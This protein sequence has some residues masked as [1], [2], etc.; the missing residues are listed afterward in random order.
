[1]KITRIAAAVAAAA[2]APA[3]FLATPALADS[4]QR[5]SA[6]APAAEAEQMP[7]VM[8]FHDLPS[9]FTAGGDWTQFSLSMENGYD[10][11]VTHYWSHIVFHT[12]GSTKGQ[13][14][15]G[16]AELQYFAGGEWH[17]L[18]VEYGDRRF[19][20]HI[21]PRA[22]PIPARD[23]HFTEWGNCPAPIDAVQPGGT[24]TLKLR[25]RFAASAPAT[26]VLAIAN[27]YASHPSGEL[28]TTWFPNRARFSIVPAEKP[29]QQ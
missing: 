26:R 14:R 5:T 23:P 11:A 2:L 7:M 9:T 29:V 21:C 19:T 15:F 10:Y 24:H 4:A 8:Q 25:M 27:D 3:L 6:S 17:P 22:N 1:M 18:V 28:S 20:T 12:T 13:L 16:D